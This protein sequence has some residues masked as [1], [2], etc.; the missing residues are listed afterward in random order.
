M[1]DLVNYYLAH[2][3]VFDAIIS[4]LANIGVL[5]SIKKFAAK[6]LSTKTLTILSAVLSTVGA[7]LT[8]F[9]GNFSGSDTLFGVYSAGIFGVTHL[10]YTLLVKP[11]TN[12]VRDVQVEK[13]NQAASDQSTATG[14][15]SQIVSPIVGSTVVDA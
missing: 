3:S 5:G 8:W 9:L 6:E 15:A 11:T 4:I 13:Q 14:S 1:Q 12:L 7:G 10:A 2:K